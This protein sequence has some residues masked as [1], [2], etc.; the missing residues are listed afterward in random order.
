MLA[1]GELQSVA[2]RTT[3]ASVQKLR[4]LGTA[5]LLLFSFMA[6][7]MACAL[8]DAQMSQEEMACC[9][10]MHGDCGRT[11]MS[12]SHGCCQKAPQANVFQVIQA[13]NHDLHPVTVAMVWLAAWQL[14]PLSS[15][16]DVW[17]KRPDAS[18][19]ESPPVSIT[20]LRI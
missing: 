12:A 13:K 11:A 9:H 1:D 18:P 3:L 7:V 19:P 10:M 16:Q 14:S 6:P 8:P 5:L 15:A 17:A 2:E 20:I 4:Q